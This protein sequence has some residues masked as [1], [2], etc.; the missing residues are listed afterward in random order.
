M[1]SVQMMKK[2]EIIFFKKNGK[3]EVMQYQDLCIKEQLQYC[4][5]GNCLCVKKH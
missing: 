2:I 5:G 1:L 3:K 4:K